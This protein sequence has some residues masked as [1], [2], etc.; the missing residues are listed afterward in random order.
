[1]PIPITEVL[2]TSKRFESYAKKL[3]ISSPSILIADIGGF[4]YRDNIRVHDLGMVCDKTIAKSLGE[5]VS[6]PDLDRFHNYVFADIRPSFIAT[7]AYHSW[8]ASLDRDTRFRE[9][10][11]PIFQYTDQWVLARYKETIISGDFIRKDI[12]IGKEEILEEIR[13]NAKDVPYAGYKK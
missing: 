6:S 3:D 2:D 1:M 5:G 10:Y 12:V 7:R 4:L 13:N 11:V 9:Y 8:L